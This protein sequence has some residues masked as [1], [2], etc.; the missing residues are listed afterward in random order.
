MTTP[1][2][3]LFSQFSLF[4]D[5]HEADL[6]QLIPLMPCQSYKQ[7]ETIFT[8]GS[9]GRELYLIAS[10]SVE[11]LKTSGSQSHVI[12]EL[13]EGSHFGELSFLDG[14]PRSTA[15]RA[16]TDLKLYALRKRFLDDD[17]CTKSMIQT[18]YRNLSLTGT[19]RLRSTDIAYSE[20]LEK[21]LVLHQEKEYINRFLITVI[22][23]YSSVL[24][25]FSL[26]QGV[27]KDVDVY[28]TTFT[29][30]F[31][32]LIVLPVLYFTTRSG[33]PWSFFGVTLSNWKRSV[34]EGLLISFGVMF[35][36]LNL[37]SLAAY[38]GLMPQTTT[39]M[40]GIVRHIFIENPFTL[41]YFF[42]SYAQE[43]LARGVF[44]NTM[45]RV[46]GEKKSWKAVV[47]ASFIFG[48]AHIPYGA[49]MVG[50]TVVSG[51]FFG[52]IFKRHNNLLGVALVHWLL[53][54]FTFLLSSLPFA[55]RLN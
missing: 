41:F 18:L 50:M 12:A 54:T 47:L 22:A 28:S 26:L 45:Q 4:N 9:S 48:V 8:E 13:P 1:N 31:V 32:L 46:F 43:F 53:G 25:L 27:F 39:T 33:E 20:I 30:L 6:V 37:L 55:E 2:T 19:A 10:G 5:V 52:Y 44:Q 51:I 35:V 15:I 29:W 16:K 7:G 38:L 34:A 3:A 14:S 49:A 11:V 40:S 23:S 21:E 17:V 36:G 42:H 24:V